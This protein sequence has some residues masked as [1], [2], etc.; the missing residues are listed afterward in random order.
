MTETL[1][2]YETDDKVGFVTLNRPEKLNALNADLRRELAAMLAKAD[3]D[4]TTS[5]VVRAVPAAAFVSAMIF[6]A[7]RAARNGGATH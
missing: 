3:E 6:P 2:L 4:R 7:A 5:L 1:V